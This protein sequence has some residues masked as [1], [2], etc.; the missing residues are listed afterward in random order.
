MKNIVI[1]VL[2]ILLFITIL[3]LYLLKKS[4]RK[5]N[6][7]LEQKV[8]TSSIML[9]TSDLSDKDLCRLIDSINHTLQKYNKTK[10]EYE[11]KNTRL[12]KMITN[13]THDIRTP[14]TSA[15]GYIDLVLKSDMPEERKQKNLKIIEERLLRLSELVDCFF[16]F[17][18]I[19]S[20]NELIQ[21][22]D[23]NLIAVLEKSIS[24]RY[25]D[26]SCVNRMIDFQTDTQKFI[27]QSN[28]I[29][30][31]RIFDNLIQNAFKHSNG[32]LCITVTTKEQITISFEN[33]LLSTEI[34][35]E[36]IFDEFYTIDISR[37][38][39]NTGLGLAIAKEF[40]RQL[41]G[42]INA[43]HNANRLSITIQLPKQT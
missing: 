8:K 34:D 33:E 37:T 16:E 5:F 3:Y 35:T 43:E 11:N 9:L 14:L 25:E 2:S 6:K 20:S 32:T 38:K 29:M 26:F 13:I 24:N 12:E 31:S 4:L 10:L 41:H 17:S 39:G 28:A 7:E 40:T 19:K 27:L 1:L 23:V 22:S 18:K 36:R 15:L 21:F 42:E 30:L